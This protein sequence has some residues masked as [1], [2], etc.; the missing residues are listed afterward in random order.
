MKSCFES[1]LSR[2]VLVVFFP[3]A[4]GREHR[5]LRSTHT[6]HNVQH[7]WYINAHSHEF[8][9]RVSLEEARARLP[10]VEPLIAADDPVAHGRLEFLGELQRVEGVEVHGQ[11][12][13]AFHG[14]LTDR[15]QHL[16]VQRCFSCVTH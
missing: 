5:T 15:H 1:H 16:A 11:T 12:P 2:D 10:N 8:E 6:K 13:R 14:E 7:H 4:E 3:N 9:R